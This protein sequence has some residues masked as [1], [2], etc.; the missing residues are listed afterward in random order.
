[1]TDVPEA[2]LER[3]LDARRRHRLPMQ[4]RPLAQAFSQQVLGVMFPHFATSVVCSEEAVIEDVIEVQESLARL[5][6][7]VATLHEKMPERLVP[8]FVEKLSEVHDLLR[9]DAQAIYEGDPAARSVDEV[10]LTYPGFYGIAVYRVAHALFQLGMPLL[11]RLL[12]EVAH[13]K[14]GIDIHP[15]AQIGRRFCIDHGTGIVVGETTNIGANV[16]LYQGVT[17]GALAVDKSFADSKRHPTLEDGVVIYAGATILGGQT[18]VG[19]NSIVAGNAFLT[20]SVP[21]DSIVSR[22]S[23]VRPRGAAAAEGFDWVI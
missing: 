1:M 21:P 11:P 14:T 18:T 23:E 2:L 22:K 3:L 17:L 6:R 4:V 13:E 9:D 7:A 15:G 16:K 5:E 8:S 10:I 20:Q 19:K 12:T